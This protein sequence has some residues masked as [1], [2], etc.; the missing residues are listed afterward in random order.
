MARM[1]R[2]LSDGD[3]PQ[4]R[5]E[6]RKRALLDEAADVLRRMPGGS[7]AEIAEGLGVSRATLYRM[8]PNRDALIRELALDAL[9][10]TDVAAASVPQNVSSYREAFAR[11]IEALVPYG[12]RYHFLMN[13]PRAMRDP[14]V[15]AGVERQYTQM[16]AFIDEAK[17][18]GEL[19]PEQPT[20]WVASVFDSI[21]WSAWWSV[22]EGNIAPKDVAELAMR[23]FWGGVRRR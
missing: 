8:F 2:P 7:M 1:R 10:L 13:E 11:L 5:A 17:A 15:K 21:I 12:D 6:A 20:R 14:E 9:H 4:R 22:S 19:D 23:S 18:A 3:K 16:Y